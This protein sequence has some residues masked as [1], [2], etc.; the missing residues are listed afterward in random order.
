MGFVPYKRSLR[1]LPPAFHH[2]RAQLEGDRCEP[3]SGPS[4]EHDHAG[5][6]ILQ[7]PT[8]IA[9]RNKFM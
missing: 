6:L 2:V 7:F 8:S 9:V 3:G 1:E 4:P 5:A